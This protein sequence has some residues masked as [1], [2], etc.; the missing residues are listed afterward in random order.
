MRRRGG[1]DGRGLTAKTG[2]REAK[3][4]RL[5]SSHLPV[6]ASSLFISRK[7]TVALPAVPQAL[8]V[9]IS[10]YSLSA[11]AAFT[12]LST[13]N[14]QPSTTPA[15]CFPSPLFYARPATQAAKWTVP[16]PLYFRDFCFEAFFDFG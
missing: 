12:S 3:G 9:L 14:P 10:S 5:V 6:F 13:I 11:S 8:K 7:R 16:A 1:A 2:R 15:V 4:E